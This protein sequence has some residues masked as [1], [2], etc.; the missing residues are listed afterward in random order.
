M[1][2]A[3]HLTRGWTCASFPINK[4]PL[5]LAPRLQI[6]AAFPKDETTCSSDSL[7]T[8]R[9]TGPGTRSR[10]TG[11]RGC[12]GS[13]AASVSLRFFEQPGHR[14]SSPTSH[15]PTSVVFQGPL[16]A[17]ASIPSSRLIFKP[18]LPST[19]F[20]Y[21][22]ALPPGASAQVGLLPPPAAIPHWSPTGRPAPACPLSQLKSLEA[23]EFHTRCPLPTALSPAHTTAA[24]RAPAP[25]AGRPHG[26]AAAL[27]A[28]YPP[29]EA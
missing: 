24:P 3:G 17:M 20:S 12:L 27:R 28:E 6:P 5:T 9:T 26:S 4:G 8:R 29:V 25:G 14:L 22:S 10:A 13:S 2:P 1:P 19:P 11:P 21:L 7:G 15:T 18:H 16:H 23:P